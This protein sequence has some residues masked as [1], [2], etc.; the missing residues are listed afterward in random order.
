M[1]VLVNVSNHP[2][3]S[4]SVEQKYGWDMIIDVPFPDVPPELDFYD[5]AYKKIAF[6][7]MYRIINAF[8]DAEAESKTTDI[9][10]FVLLQGEFSLCY[11]LFSALKDSYNFVVPTTRRKTEM[12]TMPDGHVETV[13]TFKFVRWRA[14]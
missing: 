14:I 3:T 5:T 12:K 8:I 9:S 6:D 2:S 13:H 4:W 10:R 1:K 7:T 11:V